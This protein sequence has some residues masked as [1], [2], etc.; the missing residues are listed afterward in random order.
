MVCPQFPGI[1][2]DDMVSSCSDCT[3]RTKEHN[4]HQGKDFWGQKKILV[5]IRFSVDYHDFP[6]LGPL[7][8]G[9]KHSSSRRV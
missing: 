7:L 1:K 6:Q 9:E 8:G 5:L 2:N 3:E 4:L